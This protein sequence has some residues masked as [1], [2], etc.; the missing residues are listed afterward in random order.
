MPAPRILGF[1]TSTERL[2][3][4]LVAGPE[5]L[6]H[7]SAGGA[8]AS[9]ALLPAA[10][11]LLASAGL[12]FTD[13]DAI[14]FG[15]GP[16]A[17]TGLRTSAAVAQGLALA[18][19]RPVL[20]IDSLLLVAEGGRQALA[21]G[22]PLS[23]AGGAPEPICIEVAMDA[24]LAEAYA[25]TY[26]HDGRRWTCE[27]APH[28]VPLATLALRWQAAPP[29]FAAGTA[30]ALLPAPALASTRCLDA[31]PRR[32]AALASLAA[33]AWH[34]DEPRLDAADALP[35][36]LRDKVALTTHERRA[37]ATAAP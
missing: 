22:A 9:A 10:Q 8:A 3:V 36:Y 12:R 24:R 27:V 19:A 29:A 5:P 18:L 14:A 1:D 4:A 37:A 2:V 35:V 13:L 20:S 16:G 6:L 21:E 30:L 34:G 23:P 32:A 17:F 31:E 25:A 33:A 11:A 7:E 28:L 15:R 26:R